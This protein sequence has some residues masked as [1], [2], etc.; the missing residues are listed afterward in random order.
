MS[1]KLANDND[2]P[3]SKIVDSEVRSIYADKIVGVAWGIGVSKITLAQEVNETTAKP[4]LNV[5]MPTLAL[6]E[7]VEF[8]LDSL[9]ENENLRHGLLEGLDKFRAKITQGKNK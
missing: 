3:F 6:I 1:K 2:A 9:R 8:I 5:A 4:I 7:A